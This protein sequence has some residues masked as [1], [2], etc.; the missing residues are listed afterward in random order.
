ME[1][2]KLMKQVIGILAIIVVV[3]GGVWLVKRNKQEE[4][5]V[6]EIVLEPTE[7]MET[8]LPQAM[9]EA[10]KEEIEQKF[11]NEGVEMTVL[12]DVVG[13]QAVGTA[14]RQY[15]G[16]VFSHKIEASGLKSLEKGFYYEG[17]LVGDGG[18]FSTGRLGEVEGKGTL[19]YKAD[20]DKNSFKGVVVTLEPEDGDQAPAEHVLEGSF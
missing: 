7:R 3:I 10:E 2:N 18:Y 15:D 6:P 8:E 5:T 14:W 9:T 19:Y 4:E 17:W 20:E 13:G 11:A 12:K 16:T 1:N